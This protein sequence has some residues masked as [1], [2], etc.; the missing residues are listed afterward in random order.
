MVPRRWLGVSVIQELDTFRHDPGIRQKNNYNFCFEQAKGSYV[1]LLH[2][3][4]VID[5]DFCSVM[6]AR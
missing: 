4:D 6:H 5:D 1:L 3:D 2:H